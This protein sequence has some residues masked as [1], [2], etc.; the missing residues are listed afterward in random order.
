MF[1]MPSHQPS[2]GATDKVIR[3]LI[4]KMQRN[5]NPAHVKLW[6]M[7]YLP[8]KA[9]RRVLKAERSLFKY[10]IYVPCNDRDAGRSPE[11]T[12]WRAGRNLEWLRLLKIGK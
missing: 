10:G 3:G 1:G 6:P 11:R 9:V 12:H 2:R 8:V 7:T 4:T 5:L